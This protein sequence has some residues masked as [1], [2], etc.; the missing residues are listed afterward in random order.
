MG[1]DSTWKGVPKGEPGGELMKRLVEGRKGIR[2][3]ER[4]SHLEGGV[5]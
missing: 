5:C 1:G 3:K 2:N 4:E